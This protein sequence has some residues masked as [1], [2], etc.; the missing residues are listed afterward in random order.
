MLRHNR[1]TGSNLNS[2]NLGTKLLY[3]KCSQV[4]NEDKL[5]ENSNTPLRNPVSS[6]SAK[7]QNQAKNVMGSRWNFSK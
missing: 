7:S 4:L 5:I 1:I 6:N 2:Q 3:V